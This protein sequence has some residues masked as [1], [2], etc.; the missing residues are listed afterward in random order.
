[1]VPLPET[2]NIGGESFGGEIS[3]PVMIL[4]TAN[5]YVSRLR[6]DFESF[7]SQAVHSPSQFLA[8]SH[9]N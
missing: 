4:K 8:A 3:M 7:D 2:R 6:L 5:F 1:M 9:M